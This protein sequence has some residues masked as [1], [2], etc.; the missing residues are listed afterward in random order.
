MIYL[1]K[2]MTV[3]PNVSSLY[4]NLPI[5]TA[6]FLIPRN[7]RAATEMPLSIKQE[8]CRGLSDDLPI[9]GKVIA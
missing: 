5:P 3:R 2:F 7:R 9:L 1:Q 8:I 6:S 4:G